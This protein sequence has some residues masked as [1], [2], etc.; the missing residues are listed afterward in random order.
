[1]VS[2]R[3]KFSE[4]LWLAISNVRL[5]NCSRLYSIADKVIEWS[6]NDWK[7]SQGPLRLPD[8][9]ITIV[10]CSQ[11]RFDQRVILFA[12]ASFAVMTVDPGL[13]RNEA[14]SF[15]WDDRCDL[16]PVYIKKK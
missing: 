16:R 10:F 7:H 14:R 9:V 8:C 2:I 1:M 13:V 15:E 6:R 3:L 11:V 12:A 4:D 5:R